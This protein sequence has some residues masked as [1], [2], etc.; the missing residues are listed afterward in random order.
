VVEDNGFLMKRERNYKKYNQNL[1]LQIAS[2]NE[3][4]NITAAQYPIPAPDPCEFYTYFNKYGGSTALTVG[5]NFGDACN[6]VVTNATRDTYII[7]RVQDALGAFPQG[8]QTYYVIVDYTFNVT[9]PIVRQG[10]IEL[11]NVL[12]GGGSTTI[13]PFTTAGTPVVA[14]GVWGT[15]NPTN[16][17]FKIKLPGWSGGATYS[18]NIYV[19][20]GFGNCP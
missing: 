16:N 15:G 3:T 2:N 4:I 18:G 7:V 20:V 13:I 9:A 12:T 17:Y 10:Y 19:T 8:G 11:G 14:T 5:A 6:I 1:R